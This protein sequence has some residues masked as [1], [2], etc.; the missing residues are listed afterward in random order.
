MTQQ[1]LITRQYMNG[2]LAS[3]A[4]ESPCGGQFCLI[5][6]NAPSFHRIDSCSPGCDDG[7]VLDPSSCSS[8]G[9]VPANI[10]CSPAHIGGVGVT[11]FQTT[12]SYYTPSMRVAKFLNNKYYGW[13]G[14]HI[15]EFD[16]QVENQ[17]IAGAGYPS[18]NPSGNPGGLGLWQVSASPFTQGF[19][20]GETVLGMYPMMITGVPYLVTAAA[21]GSVGFSTGGW[22]SIKLNGIT[23]TWDSGNI[24]SVPNGFLNPG[25]VGGT[26]HTE[27]R[28]KNKIYFV[29]N[30]SQFQ[31]RGLYVYNPEDDLISQVQFLNGLNGPVLR[32]PMDLCVFN[33]KLYILAPTDNAQTNQCDL[34]LW[35]V[36][37]ALAPVVTLETGIHPRTDNHDGRNALFVDNYYGS[38]P[39]LYAINY[40]ESKTGGLDGFGLWE[41]EELNGQIVNN[42]RLPSNPN[43]P[44]GVDFQGG[45]REEIWRVFTD[46]KREAG[47]G[48]LPIWEHRFAPE[49]GANYSAY[50]FNGSGTTQTF[51]ANLSVHFLFSY[52]HSRG[53]DAGARIAN[54]GEVNLDVHSIDESRAA[55][56]LLGIN[57]RL[58]PSFTNYPA[59]TPLAVR[60]FYDR[61]GHPQKEENLGTLVS[62]ASGTISG[63]RL[64]VSAISGVTNTVYWDFGSDGL[65]GGQELGFSIH[66][67]TTGVS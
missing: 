11:S 17:G 36:G 42:G 3:Y 22:R 12:R 30:G 37:G 49:R 5:G 24:I 23:G 53:N 44:R 33:D 43:M 58:I 57:F 35:R 31:G 63:K 38:K 66:A 16:A 65:S 29:S 28:H 51:W 20:Y 15:W 25:V 59:G 13:L 50:V 60:L 7:E 39:K 27:V 14:D 40:M 6:N 21:V 55:E 52:A 61:Q 45:N 41:M 62:P 64:L 4:Q 26:I 46:P 8:N 2:T 19:N 32:F 47:A 1:R 18:G 56:G 9:M 67:S 48:G 10:W 54:F 34:V